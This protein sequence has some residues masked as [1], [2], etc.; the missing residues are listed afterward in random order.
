[1]RLKSREKLSQRH[2]CW[3]ITTAKN[4]NFLANG[5]VVHNSNSRYC[6]AK[7]KDGQWTQFCGS[8]TNWMAEDEK[9]IW[10]MALRQCPAIGEWCRAHP[11]Q[12]LYGEVFGQVQS[13]KYGARPNDIFFAAFAVLD[14]SRWLDFDDAYGSVKAVPG[15]NW[16]PLLYRGPFDGAKLFELAEGDSTWP[17]ANH[18]REGCV[19]LPIKERTDPELGRVQLKLVSNRYLE[20]SK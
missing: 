19:V 7:D 12:I 6:Y 4:H 20:K 13:L 1:M 10:W 15:L 17:G 8:R 11:E 14:K 16:V 2:R 9:N 3:D 18:M 5:V